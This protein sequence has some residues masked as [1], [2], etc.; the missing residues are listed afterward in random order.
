MLILLDLI[1]DIVNQE[2]E[3]EELR[4]RKDFSDTLDHSSSWQGLDQGHFAKVIPN[5][6]Y[7]FLHLLFHDVDSYHEGIEKVVSRISRH[8]VYSLAQGIVYAV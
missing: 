7:L 2:M 4:I 6:L 1:K 3:H 8:C 5:D